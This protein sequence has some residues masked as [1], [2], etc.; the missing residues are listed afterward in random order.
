MAIIYRPLDHSRSEIRLLKILPPET[1]TTPKQDPLEFA[2]GIIRCELEYDSLDTMHAISSLEDRLYDDISKGI[3]QDVIRNREENDPDTDTI[4]LAHFLKNNFWEI[5]NSNPETL[6]KDNPER[7]ETLMLLY[8]S[9]NETMKEWLPQDSEKVAND[10]LENWFDTWIWTPLSGGDKSQAVEPLSYFAL[11]YVWRNH[12]DLNKLFPDR[13]HKDLEDKA[14]AS[15]LSL[16]QCFQVVGLSSEELDEIFGTIQGKQ[17]QIIVDG[18]PIMVGENLEKALRTVREIPEVQNGSRI[19]VDAI[20]INQNDISEKNI[21]VKR[22]GEIYRKASRVISWLGEEVDQ[23]TETM[24][25]MST[26]GRVFSHSASNSISRSF[27][28]RF[29]IDA[30]IGITRLLSR[31]YWSRIWITQEICLGG[32]R[33][34]AICGPRRYR[35][36]ELLRCGPIL[37][38]KIVQRG[39]FLNEDLLLDP[40]SETDAQYLTMGDLHAAVK[41]LMALYHANIEC[42]DEERPVPLS[43]AL[44]FRIP[45]GS[46]ASDPRDL[47]YGMIN[48]LPSNLKDLIKVDYSQEIRFVDVMVEFA[49]AH[50]TSTNNL[51]LILHQLSAPI[52][53]LN[54]WPTWVPNLALPYSS[55]HFQ[56]HYSSDACA[57]P[58]M[59]HPAAFRK[60]DSKGK[61]LLICKGFCLDTINQS[62]RIIDEVKIDR[63]TNQ[64]LQLENLSKTD[65]SMGLQS[66]LSERRHTKFI[67]ESRYVP[68]STEAPIITDLP[69]ASSEHKYVDLAGLK[70]ALMECFHRLNVS[71]SSEDDTIFDIP[72]DLDILNRE[73]EILRIQELSASFID[74]PSMSTLHEMRKLFADFSLWGLSF[75]GLFPTNL[76]DVNLNSFPIPQIHERT[77]DLARLFTTCG[78][79]VGTCICHTRPG[80]EIFLLHGCPMPVILRPSTSYEGAYELKGGV[81]MPGVMKGEAFARFQELGVEAETITI[82]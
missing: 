49:M 67:L 4:A 60:D 13:H 59:Q 45:G 28:E 51:C 72:F 35:M 61:Y 18:S 48:L 63:T 21:E 14:T 23:S 73:S 66:Y 43:N 58:A 75:K 41:K 40:G 3:F 38:S 42:R 55:A 22:M 11:S 64:V 12:P 74:S 17:A 50:I 31:P 5:A 26:V 15:G 30:A 16:R 34:I 9:Y 8:Q 79:Y 65:H 82:C 62:T 10:K 24:E 33:A 37:G 2:P 54:E 71:F 80:D 25:F 29:H 39:K 19:W 53:G 56:W 81:H 70:V 76:R 36:S 27:L 7:K 6:Y 1:P 32:D 78:G 57:C 77:T 52:F 68:D 69:L 46:R 20:C 47:V 44:W